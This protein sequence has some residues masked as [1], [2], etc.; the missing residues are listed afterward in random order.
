MEK[1][2]DQTVDSDSENELDLEWIRK[3]NDEVCAGL[4]GTLKMKLQQE[5]THSPVLGFR[6][7]THAGSMTLYRDLPSTTRI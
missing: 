7:K 5:P 3:Q 4:P 6:G 1:S 2:E